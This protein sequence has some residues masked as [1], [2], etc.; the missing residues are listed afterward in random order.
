MRVR[1]VS[2]LI[3]ILGYSVATS[4]AAAPL[5]PIKPWGVDY[6][7]T[8]CVAART[9]GSA[10]APV[11]LGIVPSISGG[12]YMLQVSEQAPGPRFA[13]ELA[14]TVDFGSGPIPSGA[15]YFGGNGV[16]ARA[17][18]FRITASQMEFART[19]SAVTF[20]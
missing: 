13:Q 17:H 11:T 14:G 5:Q 16:N 2:S 9:F 18:Q 19:A 8:Q 10:N 20:C 15:L 4:A 6:G 1:T 12:T 3:A 7:A